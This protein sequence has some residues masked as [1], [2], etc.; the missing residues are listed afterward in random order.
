VIE[1]DGPIFADEW[2]DEEWQALAGE[3]YQ[4]ELTPEEGLRYIRGPH[5]RSKEAYENWRATQPDE[6]VLP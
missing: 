4:R 6:E 5:S 1:T 2:I 3:H